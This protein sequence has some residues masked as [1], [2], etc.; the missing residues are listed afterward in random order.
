MSMFAKFIAESSAKKTQEVNPVTF[1]RN[2]DKSIA[3]YIVSGMKV[4]ESLPYIKFVRWNHVKDASKI[5]GDS[6]TVT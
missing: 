3:Y 6:A 4:I 1:K 2:T 5:T